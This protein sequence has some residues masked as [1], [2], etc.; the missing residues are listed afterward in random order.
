MKQVSPV[1]D[2]VT[3]LKAESSL[4]VDGLGNLPEHPSTVY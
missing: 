3:H 4:G 2:L 1:H